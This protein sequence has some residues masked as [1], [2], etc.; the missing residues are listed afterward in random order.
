MRVQKQRDHYYRCNGRQFARGLYGLNGK[1]C[2]GKS[3]NG[4]YVERLVWADIESFLRNPG[5]ILER[6]RERV[7]MQD[8]DR[9]ASQQKLDD[10]TDGLQQ[11]TAE[12]ERVLG[13]FRRGRIDDAE[14]DLQLDLIDAEAAGLQAEIELATRA[15]SAGDRSEQFRTAEALLAT[16]RKRLDGPVPAELKRRIVEVLV[17]SIQANTAER[18][19]VQQSE[20][21]ITYRFSQ[22]EEPAALV[23]PRYHRLSSRKQPPEELNTLGDHLLRRRLVLKLLQ[24]QVGEQLGVDKTSVAN[25]EANRTKPGFAYMPAIIRFL[26]YNPRP[27]STG[28]AER[29]VQGRTALGLFQQQAAKQIGV[30]ASTLARWERVCRAL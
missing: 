24:R 14:L 10:L 11:K 8:G 13:L 5:E 15:L 12:R 19:G 28:W 4:D 6:L 3:L 26:G 29:L 21:V 7:L 17:E 27:P 18:W 2:P 30:D 23:I 9:K 1:K 20:I 22:P 16:L 25:W